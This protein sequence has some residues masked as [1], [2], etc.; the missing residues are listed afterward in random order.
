MQKRS[1]FVEHVVESLR[2][3]GTVEARS[4]FGGWGLYHEGLFFALVADDVLYLKA[5]D[6]NR[7]EFDARGL[8]PWI[9]VPKRGERIVTQYRQAPEEGFEDAEVMA[10]W[11]RSSYGA[12]LRA[13]A[14]KAM[15]GRRSVAAKPAKPPPRR[16]KG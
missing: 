9:F 1:E 4:M 3:F 2:R 8:E 11:A 16:R 6:Q 12:A 15:K 14:K 10:K 5:D 13:A 7:G